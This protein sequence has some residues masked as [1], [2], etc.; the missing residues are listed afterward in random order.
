MSRFYKGQ[1]VIY[2]NTQG[3]VNFISEQYITICIK[4]YQK[5]PEEAEHAR[6]TVRQ[7]CIVVPPERWDYVLETQQQV[8]NKFSTE[9]AEIV[10]NLL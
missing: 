7:V 3:Y 2:D 8:S 4:E 1:L 6:E 5:P 10:E 9:N